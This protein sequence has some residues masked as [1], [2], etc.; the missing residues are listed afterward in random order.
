MMWRSLDFHRD[1]TVNYTEFLAASLS[2]SFFLKEEKLRFIFKF[3]DEKNID[4]I[5]PKVIITVLRSNELR[6]EDDEILKIFDGNGEKR[7]Y[8]EDF[9]KLMNDESK[10][11]SKST[12]V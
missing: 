12:Y 5:T 10:F 8:F 9:R 7:I 3:F 1:G 4:Y 6:V 2:S 11:S